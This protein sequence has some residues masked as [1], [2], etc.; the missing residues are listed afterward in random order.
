MKNIDKNDLNKVSGGMAWRAIQI[1]DGKRYYLDDEA[2]N[3]LTQNGYRVI[4]DITSSQ[5]NSRPDMFLYSVTDANGNG[6]GDAAMQNLL[7]PSIG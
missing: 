5:V 4:R 1:R 3:Q 6:I 2:H 7:G